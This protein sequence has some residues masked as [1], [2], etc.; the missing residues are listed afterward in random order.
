MHLNYL[1]IGVART[2][3]A[4]RHR[5]ATTT[6]SESQLLISEQLVRKVASRSYYGFFQ[7]EKTCSRR[8]LLHACS[9]STCGD[10]HAT[11]VW[12]SSFEAFPALENPRR[13]VP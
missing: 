4:D 1:S 12:R 5:L 11:A 3:F 10:R 8:A 9:D 6:L 13:G 2:P 7:C